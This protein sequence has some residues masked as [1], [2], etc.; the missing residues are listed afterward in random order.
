MNKKDYLSNTR[1]GNACIQG[2]FVFEWTI[3]HS[4]ISCGFVCEEKKERQRWAFSIL[5]RTVGTMDQ[6]TLANV[7][8]ILTKIKDKDIASTLHATSILLHVYLRSPLS[9]FA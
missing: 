3:I 9:L 4:N 2:A 6:E 8:A 1:K 7:Q 5:Q